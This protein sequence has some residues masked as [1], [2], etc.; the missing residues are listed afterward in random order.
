MNCTLLPDGA[1]QG[2]LLLPD[3]A[4]ADPRASLINKFLGEWNDAVAYL[5]NS[6]QLS[7]M[8]LLYWIEYF[9]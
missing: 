8:Q 3:L 9:L 7:Q 6:L 2:V 4:P 5:A 1:Y